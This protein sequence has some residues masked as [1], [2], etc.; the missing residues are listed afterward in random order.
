MTCANWFLSLQIEPQ[1]FYSGEGLY[2][3]TIVS[4]V[5]YSEFYCLSEFY[6][7]IIT[8]TDIHTTPHYSQMPLID[9][10]HLNG[11]SWMS[12][13]ISRAEMPKLE[14]Y[15][16]AVTATSTRLVN[17]LYLSGVELQRVKEWR[18][19]GVTLDSKL[20]FIPHTRLSCTKA[21]RA[22]GVLCRNFR[23]KASN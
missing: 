1:G 12:G 5:L 15:K 14:L 18:Y 23:D 4:R 8:D 7:F 11:C 9:P 22:I 10:L 20:S 17:T 19:L 16:T 2:L 13:K 6:C 3:P 21:K